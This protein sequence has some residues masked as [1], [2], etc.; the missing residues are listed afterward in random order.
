MTT[1]VENA[2]LLN[3]KLGTALEGDDRDLK[4]DVLQG[5]AD[6]LG[7]DPEA[8]HTE[9]LR[10]QLGSVVDAEL[11]DTVSLEQ[12]QDW[13]E[14]AAA[15][16]EGVVREINATTS[17]PAAQEPSQTS[18]TVRVNSRIAAYGGTFTDPGQDEG[19]RVVRD[20]AVTVRPTAAVARA[21]ADG[22][23]IKIKG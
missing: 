5:W 22:T 1:K 20:Q 9:I 2:S 19:R 16:P 10:Y 7:D 21:L 4:A 12:L 8:V 14:R 23:L 17:P 6:R 15:D 3:E 13:M 11:P 18:L